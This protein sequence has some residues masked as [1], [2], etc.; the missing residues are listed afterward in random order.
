LATEEQERRAVAQADLIQVELRWNGGSLD[1]EITNHGSEPTRDVELVDVRRTPPNPSEAWRPN[2]NISPR[3]R[4]SQS[5]LKGHEKMRVILWLLDA[6]GAHIT[7]PP[8]GCAYTIRYQDVSGQSWERKD[9][10]L[11]YRV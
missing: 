9:T 7:Q 10:G 3:S 6:T 1:L 2:P 4:T 5:V 11:P 8:S